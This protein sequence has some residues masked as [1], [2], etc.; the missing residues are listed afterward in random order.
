M[1]QL[2][3]L[4]HNV[5]SWSIKRHELTNTYSTLS[6]DIILINHTGI[7]QD[8]QLKIYQY[9]VYT[10]NKNNIQNGGTAI[11]IKN[12]IA[13]TII[14]DFDTELLAINVN[15][16]EATI[17]IGTDYLQPSTPYLDF[18]EYNKLF[19]RRNPVYFLGDINA[20]HNSLGHNN[21]NPVG[22]GLNT[23]MLR[24]TARHLGPHFPTFMRSNSSTTPD[25]VLSNNR[26]F[27]NI[28]LQPGPVTTSDHIPIIATIT[29]NPIQ[30]P[31]KPRPHFERANWEG[32]Q[33]DLSGYSGVAPSNATP[34]QIDQAITDWTNEV[35]RAAENNI[36]TLHYRIIP[37]ATPNEDIR[38]T[39]REL[40]EVYTLIRTYGPLQH[41]TD[42]LT[43]LRHTLRQ[44]FIAARTN[45]W[46]EI[47]RKI[48]LNDDPS[49]FWKSVKRFQGNKKQ[50]MSYLRDNSGNKVQTNHEKQQLFTEYMR[51]IYTE[52]TPE[53]DDE[54]NFDMNNIRLVN[55]HVTHHALWNHPYPQADV[56]RL[57]ITFPPATLDEL[58]KLIKTRKQRAPGP[59]GLTAIHLKKLPENMIRVLLDLFNKT[60][61]LGH[62]PTPF[63]KSHTIFIP[64]PSLSQHKVENYRPIT[65]L[66]THGKILDKL[67][68]ER[69]KHQ[70]IFTQNMNPRQH[71]FT[72]WKGTN[73]ALATIYETI[74][75]KHANKE[76]VKLVCRD[77]SKA[78]D[79]VWHAGLI[80]KINR[81]GLPSCLSRLLISYL[82][83]RHTSVRIQNT[84]GSPIPLGRGVPQGG[85]LSPTLYNIFVQDTPAPEPFSE[86]VMYADDLTQIVS[87]RK[88][89]FLNHTTKYAIENITNHE[90]KW[91][92]ETNLR[93]FKIVKL[94]HRNTPPITIYGDTRLEHTTKGTVLGL[95]LT[96]SGSQKSQVTKRISCARVHLD[97]LWKLRDLSAANKLKIYKATV[98]A[99]LIYPCVPLNTMSDA[100]FIRMQVIQNDAIRIITRTRRSDRTIMAN[101]HRLLGID[102]INITIHK[103]AR[104]TWENMKNI[105]SELYNSIVSDYKPS[106]QTWYYPSSR[107]KA[108]GNTPRPLYSSTRQPRPRLVDN[109]LHSSEPET[110]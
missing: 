94:F 33:T 107:I 19:R 30:I 6:P 40:R 109:L 99:S 50:E 71:G 65:L 36:P 106:R 53:R 83:N 23:L 81:L 25:I 63:K 18:P 13:H 76:K 57:D 3:I 32:Y 86:H 48:E 80:Y 97:R 10:S 85:C 42:R 72:S 56:S 62:F 7:K 38:Q 88:L 78:F 47:I 92:I 15:T 41:Y 58:K 44:Q 61:S 22:T 51:P 45:T 55:S 20:R 103:Q 75:N 105:H 16:P 95:E 73:T 8:Q 31:I 37:G 100:Q 43:R 91:K 4:Q 1:Y 49:S 60:M 2:Q 64:K 68:N 89:P 5:N 46:D 67:L 52:N 24:D 9:T 66:D 98:R 102:P 34:E 70:L 11:A 21:R 17:T 27:H 87:Y 39:H 84:L 74:A 77:I 28:L 14:D 12:N 26:T 93:K 110:D 35:L 82:N 54:L 96:T 59:T 104:N 90:R 29:T 69:L 79:K 108:E 101:Q